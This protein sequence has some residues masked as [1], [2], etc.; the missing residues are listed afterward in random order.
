MGDQQNPDRIYQPPGNTSRY[1]L[2]PPAPPNESVRIK[3]EFMRVLNAGKGVIDLGR[4][5]L[6]D[7]CSTDLTDDPR[8][9]GFLFT[10]HAY[11]P[12]CSQTGL[13]SIRR[14]NEER[15]IR[16]WC[17]PGMS[18]ADW[19]RQVRGGNNTITIEWLDQWSSR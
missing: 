18:F 11:G 19:I 5:V 16:A 7:C 15:F 2:E 17:P 14:Y 12:C 3:R 9:G 6:C 10:N 13:A 4:T 8:Q 1:P